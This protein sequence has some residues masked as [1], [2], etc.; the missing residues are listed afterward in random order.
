MTVTAVPAAITEIR[1]QLENYG[2][3]LNGLRAAER[4]DES[5]AEM[6]QIVEEIGF[7]DHVYRVEQRRAEIDAMEAGFQLPSAGPRGGTQRADLPDTR[8]VGQR[9]TDNDEYR[10]WASRPGS[11]TFEM[12]VRALVDSTGGVDWSSA[13]ANGAGLLRPVGTPTMPPQTM[14]RTRLFIRD[15]LTVVSTTL[16]NVP[17]IK[18]LNAEANAGQASGSSA[19]G[20]QFVNEGAQKPEVALQFQPD[21][22]PI[23]KVSA[24]IP[25][26]YEILQDAPTLRGYID[27]RL[28]YMVD[29][30]EERGLLNGNGTAPNLRGILQSGPQTQS[31]A[32]T[33]EAFA[34]LGAALGKIEGV[35]GEPSFVAMNPADYWSS[36]TARHANTF[37]GGTTSGSAPFGAPPAQVWGVPVIRTNAMQPKQALVGSRLGAVVLDREQSVIRVG[38]QHLD[39]FTTN[40]VAVLCEKRVGLAVHRPDWFCVATLS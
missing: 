16:S 29:V 32:G 24:W 39:Y 13:A 2:E 4:T 25:V 26:T 22:A 1:T 34:T 36:V 21:D 12:E 27:S 40:R 38:D 20:A 6:R 30:S 17:Y 8:T 28:R 3:R 7:L 9:F 35:D 37:D 33:G 18:E 31:S 5:R 15:A 19:S 11:G 23:R 14:V 10:N